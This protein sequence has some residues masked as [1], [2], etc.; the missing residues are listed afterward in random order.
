M[1]DALYDE[2]HDIL[3]L[4]GE[5]RATLTIAYERVVSLYPDRPTRIPETHCINGMWLSGWDFPTIYPRR[6]A[7]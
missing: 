6:G 2:S 7:E 4:A 5:K 1:T 3:P